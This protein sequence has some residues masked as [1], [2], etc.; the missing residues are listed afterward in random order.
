MI[1]FEIPFCRDIDMAT[2]QWENHFR[3]RESLARVR[4][5]WK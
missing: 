3:I 1:D 5:N 4:K 2:I